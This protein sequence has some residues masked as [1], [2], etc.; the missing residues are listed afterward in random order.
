MILTDCQYGNVMHALISLLLLLPLLLPL[1]LLQ[2]RGAR[3]RAVGVAEDAF[4]GLMKGMALYKLTAHK[5]R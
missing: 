2:A 1:T 4:E 5:V 3:G